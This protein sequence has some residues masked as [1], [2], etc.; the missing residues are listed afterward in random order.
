MRG[1]GSNHKLLCSRST[2]GCLKIS[3]SIA[4]KIKYRIQENGEIAV[5][6]TE[7][8]D[9]GYTKFSMDYMVMNSE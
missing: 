8:A 7:V 3:K 1:G 6:E 5:P 4:I 9:K 2:L